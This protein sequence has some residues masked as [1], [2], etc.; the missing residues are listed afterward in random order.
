MVFAHRRWSPFHFLEHNVRE[1]SKI[2]SFSGQGNGILLPK[3]FWASD[4]EKVLKLEVEGH[5]FAN[6][7]RSVDQFKQSKVRTIFGNRIIIWIW[8]SS[9]IVLNYLPTVRKKCC[10]MFLNPNHCSDLSMF[11]KI[12]LVIS[13][14]FQS[15]SLSQEHFFP[16]LRLL[17]VF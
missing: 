9:K 15:F 17:Y 1:I 12:V 3:L 13:K 2:V 7:L 6:F 8:K 10:S 16:T 14:I 4:R 11:K 5:E